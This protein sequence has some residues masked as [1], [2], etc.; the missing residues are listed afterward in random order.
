MKNSVQID[1]SFKQ[2]LSVVK[3]LSQQQKLELSREL[4]KELIDSKFSKLMSAFKT[5]A[6][7]EEDINAEVEIVRASRYEKRKHPNN[8]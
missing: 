8:H 2:I 4:E 6:I 3:K 5:D 7:S 1:L